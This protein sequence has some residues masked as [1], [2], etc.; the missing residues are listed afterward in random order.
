MGG[1]VQKK[2]PLGRAPVQWPP[3]VRGSAYQCLLRFGLAFGHAML[4]CDFPDCR[5]VADG[6]EIVGVVIA[7]RCFSFRCRWLPPRGNWRSGP[8]KASAPTTARATR[9]EAE[10]AER[11]AGQMRPCTPLTSASTPRESAFKPVPHPAAPVGQSSQTRRHHLTPTPYSNFARTCKVA[12]K[13]VFSLTP[14]AARSLFGADKK[15]MGGASPVET[16][17]WREPVSPGG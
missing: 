14:G 17:P 4:F 1:T 13:S 11:G 7:L 10:R 15:R 3:R 12:T 16:A 5:P 9:S 8:I 2:R 6:A